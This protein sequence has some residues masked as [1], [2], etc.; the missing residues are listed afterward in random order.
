MSQEVG[1]GEVARGD[2]HHL[3]LPQ[4]RRDALDQLL[5]DVGLGGDIDQVRRGDRGQVSGDGVDARRLLLAL[6][7]AFPGRGKMAGKSRNRRR[8]MISLA[9]EI[10]NGRRLTQEDDLTVLL[11]ADLESAHG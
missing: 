2:K 10:M 1:G 11:E 7:P 6:L 8:D 5:V 3:A 4:Q 9:K